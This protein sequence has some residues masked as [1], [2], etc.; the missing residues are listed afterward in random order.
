MHVT[1][2]SGRQV[3][4]G[5]L[6][7]IE[8]GRVGC[9]TRTLPA[10][11]LDRSPEALGWAE[12]E[13]GNWKPAQKIKGDRS[14]QWTPHLENK[15]G[16]KIQQRPAEPVGQVSGHFGEEELESPRHA[17]GLVRGPSGLALKMSTTPDGV[18]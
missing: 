5:D 14:F 15:K 16:R 4:S 3:L 13:R 8:Q 12:D 1:I 17:L 6:V 18:K 10:E 7:F 11:I 2:E 9:R